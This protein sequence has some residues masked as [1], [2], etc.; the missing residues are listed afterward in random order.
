MQKLDDALIN[1]KYLRRNKY[2]SKEFEKNENTAYQNI[3]N[4]AKVFQI[5][6][7]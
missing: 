5:Y 2:L 3:W 6:F 4:V 1:N 7:V